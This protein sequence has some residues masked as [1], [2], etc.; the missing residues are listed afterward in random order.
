MLIC[1]ELIPIKKTPMYWASRLPI[2]GWHAYI[3]LSHFIIHYIPLHT[4]QYVNRQTVFYYLTLSMP[5]CWTWY[6]R[7]QKIQHTGSLF[8][9]GFKVFRVLDSNHMVLSYD[10]NILWWIV[11]V[12]ISYHVIFLREFHVFHLERSPIQIPLAKKDC[13]EIQTIEL[14]LATPSFLSR[15]GYVIT[16]CSTT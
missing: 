6:D 8:W 1:I 7:L 9:L 10:Y 11:H 16:S 14:G 2:Q 12:I 3:E 4:F 5:C 15:V 13:L